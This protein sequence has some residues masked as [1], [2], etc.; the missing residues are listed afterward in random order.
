MKCI[1][2][3][4]PEL[5]ETCWCMHLCLRPSVSPSCISPETFAAC[6]VRP[7]ILLFGEMANHLGWRGPKAHSPHD[8][9]IHAGFESDH[10]LS[11]SGSHENGTSPRHPIDTC[12]HDIRYTCPGSSSGLM[13]LKGSDGV[14]CNPCSLRV[15][16]CLCV[17]AS[18]CVC[19]SLFV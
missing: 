4:Q 17:K 3:S 16:K 18:V 1:N 7:F 13:I 14:P 8:V 12:T 11:F 2:M 5:S 6:Q 10:F 15:W 9:F 19:K